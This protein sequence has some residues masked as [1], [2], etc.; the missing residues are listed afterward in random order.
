MLDRADDVVEEGLT[1]RGKGVGNSRTALVKATSWFQPED[2]DRVLTGD[3]VGR[4]V[5]AGG[6]GD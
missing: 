3:L 6:N 4:I 5:V 1:V 2:D